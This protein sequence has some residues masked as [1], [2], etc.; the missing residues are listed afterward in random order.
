MKNVHVSVQEAGNEIVFLRRVEPG[1]ADKSYGIEVARLAGLPHDVI[2][3]A[4]EILRRHEQSEEKLTAELSPGVAAAAP[5]ADQLHGDRRIGARSAAQRGLEPADAARS[6]E[7]ARGAAEAALMNK[8]ARRERDARAGNDVG[9]VGGRNRRGAR[10]HLRRAAGDLSRSSKRIIT[11]LSR[12]TCAKQ[13]LRL[14]NGGATTTAEIS[15]LNFVLGEEFARA[16]IAACKK[17][18]HAARRDLA[19]R[20]ARPDRLSSGRAGAID[21]A[22]GAW[23]PRCRSANQHDRRAHRNSHDCE[24]PP[25]GH[26]RGRTGRAAG[27]VCR[28]SA[29]SRCAARP[30]GAEYRRNRQRDG[31]SR[32]A[33]ARKTCSPSTP[34]R[35]T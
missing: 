10:A 8:T 30:R 16:A 23:P 2:V 12:R 17:C 24:F 1:S 9:H 13:I 27:P 3:R 26:G 5:A 11:F 15:G 21:Q 25:G 33:A 19:D 29:L 18:G 7:S 20:L 4:R 35:E 31:D 22:P 32:G 34:A 14:A 28:L 6:A